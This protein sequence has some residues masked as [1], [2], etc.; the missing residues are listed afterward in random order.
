MEKV[1]LVHRPSLAAPLRILIVTQLLCAASAAVTQQ[2]TVASTNIDDE[3]GLHQ[4]ALRLEKHTPTQGAASQLDL[5]N[6]LVELGPKF[7]SDGF[8]EEGQDQSVL[9]GNDF[10]TY[11][12]GKYVMNLQMPGDESSWGSFDILSKQ[13]GKVSGHIGR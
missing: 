7:G 3:L 13:S 9:A 2:P 11:A 10:F 4:R 5:H 6:S 8:D 12:N 1:N